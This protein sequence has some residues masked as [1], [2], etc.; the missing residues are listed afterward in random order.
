[1]TTF[2]SSAVAWATI[3]AFAQSASSAPPAKGPLVYRDYDQAEL[4]AAY[5][6]TVW[7]P[8]SAQ[9]EERFASASTLARKR[10]GEPQRFAYGPTPIEQVEVFRTDRPNAPVQLFLHGGA[11]RRG[12]A[13]DYSFVA[14]AFVKAGAHVVIPDFAWVQDVNGSLT[15]MADQVRRAIAWTIRNSSTFGGD[16]SR[17]YVTGHS[18]GGHLAAAALTTDWPRLG[19]PSSPFTAALCISGIYDL[20]GARLSSR[21]NYVRFDDETEEALSPIRHL[22][23]LTCPVAVAYASLDS[24]EFQR[25]SV[26]LADALQK[27]RRLTALVRLDAYNHFEEMETFANPYGILGSLALRQMELG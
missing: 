1:M 17:L 25:Q 11:W 27:R 2:A 5:D 18:S 20:K 10:V 6:Q 4:D 3:P 13:R 24:P 23:R 14:E 8:N 19:L 22:D 12:R 26:E 9:I 21:R 7:A 15:A 16:A